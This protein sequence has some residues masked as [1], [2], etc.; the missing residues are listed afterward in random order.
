[1]VDAAVSEIEDAQRPDGY[2]NTYFTFERAAERWTNFDLHEMYCAG[3]LF[4]AAVAH[5]RATGSGRLFAVATRFA[6]HICDTFGP[7]AGKR[8]AVD[9]HE[10]VEMALVEL[11]RVR[12]R[13]G[14]W[15]GR[16]TSLTSADMAC[17]ADL[18]GYTTRPTARTT[19]RSASRAKS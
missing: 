19:N 2:L 11:Y 6:D 15:K 7:D 9:G 14:T 5:F 3:H 17:S 1:M 10:E 8:Q 18:T 12:E 16:A 4:Q 13:S